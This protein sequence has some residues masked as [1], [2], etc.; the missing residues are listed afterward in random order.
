[1]VTYRDADDLVAQLRRVA[2]D[3]EARVAIAA[4]G[5]AR[6][7]RDHTYAR[8]IAQLAEIMEGRL[9]G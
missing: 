1:V 9:R 4:A 8:R 5:H 3:D 7:L 2:A 6:T